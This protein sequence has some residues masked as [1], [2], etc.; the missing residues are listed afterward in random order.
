MIAVIFMPMNWLWTSVIILRRT[1][2]I[3]MKH[4]FDNESLNSCYF[5]S[6]SN[7]N[8]LFFFVPY[9]GKLNIYRFIYQYIYIV[10][11]DYKSILFLTWLAFLPMMHESSLDYMHTYTYW[12][13][14]WILWER[15]K[16][17]GYY[18]VTHSF[19]TK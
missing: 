16:W 9:D 3:V 17:W 19:Q 10:L 11:R 13:Y 14:I 2:K 12:E 18:L 5:F 4:N 15:G 1:A 8:I 7:N 6:S